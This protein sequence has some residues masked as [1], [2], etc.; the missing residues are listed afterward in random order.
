[1]RLENRAYADFLTLTRK[2]SVQMR[3]SDIEDLLIKPIQ[4]L[5]KY[6]L[7]FKDL[8]KHT[9][10]DHPDYLNIQNSLEQFEKINNENN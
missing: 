10:K 1:M 3:G 2:T 7:L 4:R 6:V 5:P 9:E 8:I